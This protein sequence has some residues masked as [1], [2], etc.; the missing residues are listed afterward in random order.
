MVEPVRGYPGARLMRHRR[1]L[2]G[3]KHGSRGSY[4][5]GCQCDRC[6]DAASL[7]SRERKR[8]LKAQAR[9]RVGQR[10]DSGP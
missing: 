4:N 10:I 5:A 6:T 8:R 9:S 3:V 7:Y 1:I 2:E